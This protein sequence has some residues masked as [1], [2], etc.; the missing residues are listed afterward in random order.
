MHTS[1]APSMRRRRRLRSLGSITAVLA[2][3]MAALGSCT[4]APGAADRRVHAAPGAASQVAAV[5][6]GRNGR[7]G[8]LGSRASLPTGQPLQTRAVPGWGFRPGQSAYFTALGADGSV[9]IANEP[10][11]DNQIL[12]TATDMVLSTFNPTTQTFRN[13]SV[14]TS[15]GA[16]A[17]ANPQPGP[18]SGLGG[19]DISDVQAV[20][21]GGSTRVAF[22][23]AVPYH[24]WDVQRLG[25][26][27]TFGYLTQQAGG[28]AVDTPSSRT[29]DD[30]RRSAPAAAQWVCPTNNA[31]LQPV[32]QCLGF[33]EIAVLPRSHNFVV[34]LYFENDAQHSSGGL[35][36]LSPDGRLLSAYRYPEVVLPDGRH[37]GIHPREVDAD[38]TSAPGDERFVVIFDTFDD[39]GSTLPFALQEFRVRSN[40]SIS[41]VSS[42]VLPRTGGDIGFE[43]AAY[44]GLGN[45]W[46]AETR[47]H[48]L[49]G[50]PIGVYRG[51]AGHRRLNAPACAATSGWVARWGT[52][53]APDVEMS[54]T[55]GRGIV[56]SLVEDPVTHSL[57]V[58][59]MSGYLVVIK[60]SG[61]GW[62]ARPPVNLGLDQLVDRT[63]RWIGPRKGV[64]D[65]ARRAL[66]LPVEQL[67][68]PWV[69]AAFPCAPQALDQWLYR[70]DL[71]TLLK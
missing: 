1:F 23:A 46:V 63:H 65:P 29:A 50:G 9:I 68:S 38:P 30:I 7:F 32:T 49:A 26:F 64:V 52:A 51:T 22:I 67:A 34:T 8:A 11:T 48:T 17:A 54:A 42:A 43:T 41:P 15:S 71:T 5:L 4:L 47:Q 10:Q 39:R 31:Y 57:L 53:C 66:W 18:T 36:V 58:A 40:A 2:L 28:W 55:D 44:D 19:A 70:F 16:A 12:S 14:P 21:S 37:L 20:T 24:G 59:T 62:T 25:T 3:V 13:L 6:Y 69:C 33:A 60:P 27:P 61:P 35:A 45:L 56:R